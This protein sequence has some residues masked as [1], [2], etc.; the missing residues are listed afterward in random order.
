[1]VKDINALLDKQ[2]KETFNEV[3]K[4]KP[5]KTAQRSWLLNYIT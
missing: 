5:L 1:M 4:I 3:L 2:K